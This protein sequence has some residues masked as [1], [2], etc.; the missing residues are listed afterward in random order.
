[1]ALGQLRLYPAGQSPGPEGHPARPGGGSVLPRDAGKDLDRPHD[2]R[3]ARQL[4]A[5]PGRRRLGH[6]REGLAPGAPRRPRQFA[7]P[8]DGPQHRGADRF[9]RRAGE[10]VLGPQRRKGHQHPAAGRTLPPRLGRGGRVRRHGQRRPPHRRRGQQARSRRR[11]RHRNRRDARTGHRRQQRRRPGRA[12]PPRDHAEAARTGSDAHPES[13]GDGLRH[14][15]GSPR[16]GHRIGH[17]RRRRRRWNRRGRRRGHRDRRRNRGRGRLRLRKRWR[18]RGWRRRGD[19]TGGGTGSGTGSG[20][21]TGT[22]RAAA[23]ERRRH[24]NRYRH[25]QRTGTGGGGSGTGT[26]T[27]GGSGGRNGNGRRIRN[28]T[29]RL[30][31]ETRRPENP[32]RH[33]PVSRLDLVRPD[34]Q[35]PGGNRPTDADRRCRGARIPPLARPPAAGRL[36]IRPPAPRAPEEVPGGRSARSHARLDDRGGEEE[37][38]PGRRLRK[39]LP[40]PS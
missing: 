4:Q 16:R 37:G 10:A 39:V 14:G 9:P 18:R 27:G 3:S 25:G 5:P 15:R 31:A 13:P 24:R 7:G 40:R 8:P 26:G 20:T 17:R 22:G 11:A 38:K 6:G 23:P 35:E 28:G 30:R 2:A 32:V 19:G 12:G 21:G 36:P 33:G 34:P 29:E 1:M